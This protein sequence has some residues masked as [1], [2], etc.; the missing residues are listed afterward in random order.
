MKN[1][2]WIL[3]AAGVI[4]IGTFAFSLAPDLYR[5]LKIRAM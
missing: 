5:Y 3:V 2:K 1:A 4:A